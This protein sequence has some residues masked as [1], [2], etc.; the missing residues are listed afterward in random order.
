MSFRT[1]EQTHLYVICLE[2]FEIVAPDANLLGSSFLAT[3]Q[4]ESATKSTDYGAE[5]ATRVRVRRYTT[6]RNGENTHYLNF[7]VFLSV[8]DRKKEEDSEYVHLELT[9]GVTN[10]TICSTD[11]RLQ[12]FA[13]TD[14]FEPAHVELYSPGDDATAGVV[15]R[16]VISSARQTR[17][18]SEE[19][20]PH[21]S[22]DV[23]KVPTDEP[24][25]AFF[26]EELD[27]QVWHLFSTC[28]PEQAQEYVDQAQQESSQDPHNFAVD[29]L[30]TIHEGPESPGSVELDQLGISIERERRSASPSPPPHGIGSVEHEQEGQTATAGDEGGAERDDVIV[31]DVE[32]EHQ[33]EGGLE[34]DDRGAL[35]SDAF[36][37]LEG[38]EPSRPGSRKTSPTEQQKFYQTPIDLVN[39][40]GG[41]SSRTVGAQE[42]VSLGSE[43]NQSSILP[44][45]DDDD[46]NLPLPPI[47]PEL[48]TVKIVQLRKSPEQGGAPLFSQA[49]DRSRAQDAPPHGEKAAERHLSFSTSRGSPPLNEM[50]P[51][52]RDLSVS[53]RG[54]IEIDMRSGASPSEVNTGVASSS[55]SGPAVRKISSKPPTPD[56]TVEVQQ[57]PQ[58]ER[59]KPLTP[60]VIKE[61]PVRR[62]SGAGL[63]SSRGA[64][65]NVDFAQPPTE[66]DL[67]LSE[68]KSQHV[69]DL[70]HDLSSFT[71][72]SSAGCADVQTLHQ[73]NFQTG[74]SSSS[75]SACS[76]S[77]TVGPPAPLV[78]DNLNRSDTSARTAS[79]DS[80][81]KIFGGSA[82]STP[83]VATAPPTLLKQHQSSNSGAALTSTPTLQNTILRRDHQLLSD[84]TLA[85]TILPGTSNLNQ[86]ESL[87]R[88]VNTV[89]P[90]TE[91]NDS[92]S[93]A[94]TI[95][96]PNKSQLLD[97]SVQSLFSGETARRI[98]T[99]DQSSRTG[100]VSNLASTG[101]QQY[102]RGGTGA[103]LL[104]ANYYAKQVDDERKIEVQKTSMAGSGVYSDPPAAQA[105]TSSSRAARLRSP[106]F[107][108]DEQEFR[109]QESLQQEVE[110]DAKPP[111][112]AEAQMRSKESNRSERPA[113]RKLGTSK[114]TSPMDIW[115]TASKESASVQH[116]QEPQVLGDQDLRGS[117]NVSD[118]IVKAATEERKEQQ[119]GGQEPPATQAKE[120]QGVTLLKTNKPRDIRVD[121]A[122][123][124]ASHD[125]ARFASRE[126][127]DNYHPAGAPAASNQMSKRVQ[128][129]IMQNR[130]PPRYNYENEQPRRVSVQSLH[131]EYDSPGEQ[132]GREVVTQSVVHQ[133]GAS[134]TSNQHQLQTIGNNGNSSSSS[135]TGQRTDSQHSTEVSKDRII[136]TGW[137]EPAPTFSLMAPDS[138]HELQFSGRKTRSRKGSEDLASAS[139][140]VVPQVLGAQPP[141][142]LTPP[143]LAQPQFGA[144]KPLP[145]SSAE[146][147]RGDVDNLLFSSGTS[148]PSSA[149]QVPRDGLL[150]PPP[151]P[152]TKAA[153]SASCSSSSAISMKN[154]GQQAAPARVVM[155][156]PRSARRPITPA[157]AT[158]TTATQPAFLQQTPPLPP[159][160][161]TRLKNTAV[162]FDPGLPPRGPPTTGG[163]ATAVPDVG[164]PVLIQ[165][166][167][168]AIA[169]EQ[170]AGVLQEHENAAFHDTAV[171]A[172]PTPTRMTEL[173]Q[174]N[175]PTLQH[176]VSSPLRKPETEDDLQRS[177]KIHEKIN[178]VAG[179]LETQLGSP[180]G[181]ATASS[182]AAKAAGA[183]RRNKS[184]PPK[185]RLNQ[186]VV[187]HV[188]ARPPAGPAGASRANAQAEERQQQEEKNF[189]EQIPMVKQVD[190][191]ASLD[192]TENELTPS[193]AQHTASSKRKLSYG[194][195][196][197]SA[198]PVSDIH[199]GQHPDVS[200]QNDVTN[201]S[202]VLAEESARASNTSLPRYML[203]RSNSPRKRRHNVVEIGAE[204]H[205]SSSTSAT[206]RHRVASRGASGPP[207]AGHQRA[208]PRQ[209]RLSLIQHLRDDEDDDEAGIPSIREPQFKP[210]D[211]TFSFAAQGGMALASG[212]LA[213]AASSSRPGSATASSSSTGPMLSD[214][215]NANFPVTTSSRRPSHESSVGSRSFLQQ[216]SQ[217]HFP[218]SLQR[219]SPTSDPTGTT[220]RLV[221]PVQNFPLNGYSS[222]SAMS[223]KNPTFVSVS[224]SPHEQNFGGQQEQHQ[225]AQHM[226]EQERK[227]VELQRQLH[228]MKMQIQQRKQAGAVGGA[229]VVEQQFAAQ[230]RAFPPQ[231][232]YQRPLAGNSNS[233]SASASSTT[234]RSATGFANTPAP[235]QHVEHWTSATA[236]SSRGYHTEEEASMRMPS[237]EA[238]GSSHR[239]GSLRPRTPR[240]PPRV[241]MQPSDPSGPAPLPPSRPSGPPSFVTRPS[242]VQQQAHIHGSHQDHFGATHY[243]PQVDRAAAIAQLVGSATPAGVASTSADRYSYAAQQQQLAAHAQ[244]PAPRPAAEQH[245][246]Q[247]NQ[248]HFLEQQK[249]AHYPPPGPRLRQELQPP[250]FVQQMNNERHHHNFG[251]NVAP[252]ARGQH[253]DPNSHI[254]GGPSPP[255]SGAAMKAHYPRPLMA[256]AAGA[257][258]T[259]ALPRGGGAMP[260]A[261]NHH[262]D[263]FVDIDD[264]L[265]H[266]R[267]PQI[268][269]PRLMREHDFQ[270]RSESHGST[271][272]I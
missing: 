232:L 90:D 203:P 170:S 136:W 113:N 93:G 8:H 263:L 199:P 39:A 161:D 206:T 58:D 104:R 258:A 208:V 267:V 172:P 257:G 63:S 253:H 92:V 116:Q 35:L 179:M 197:G 109:F 214:Q 272:G 75:T 71:M 251:D 132:E 14:N 98:L 84:D 180:V 207:H 178:K 212:G 254:R 74:G 23:E 68:Q 217:Q 238:G 185:T 182:T 15:A 265:H 226:D 11:I 86:N 103:N 41:P 249:A 162:I 201:D 65:S 126:Q 130:N 111:S 81:T 64:D 128:Q 165:R 269:V 24:E 191:S 246:P 43:S 110:V 233:G 247:R 240:D 44:E 196:R 186:R 129:A 228:E 231:T 26:V 168:I 77:T 30:S 91:Y 210:P 95:V 215:Q 17:V 48:P 211:R 202:S 82:T 221:P 146:G 112:F 69:V 237:N 5:D 156:R 262:T 115:P 59:S 195:G 10:A 160:G 55:S 31:E 73:T 20:L 169:K 119:S 192:D 173:I 200:N 52:R 80:A 102:I 181:A 235:R 266:A 239:S 27:A 174:K 259:T 99:P 124:F 264:Q 175:M 25:V 229:H 225:Q 89:L 224:S 127:D 34:V 131:T 49:D 213:A 255:G 83:A 256:A 209:T 7:V 158:T 135:T 163:S 137:E 223:S 88:S 72:N 22:Q 187:Q 29:H 220:A 106:V 141:T 4:L 66:D 123:T 245:F 148:G 57:R 94:A 1:L 51:G 120:G 198:I 12:D 205:A 40:G 234:P 2:S 139:G 193:Y 164:P 67:H 108:P 144:A 133:Q 151:L 6:S 114:S 60:E 260:G 100:P 183:I 250:A 97:N 155:D 171:V 134:A 76:S 105:A 13:Q 3:W 184:S 16:A 153:S 230:P 28:Y 194:G 125:S 189:E 216:H 261:S 70:V 222:G 176:Y 166:E 188:R 32:I 50:P 248:L 270:Q 78:T 61:R 36:G 42:V 242:P 38:K 45:D 118:F 53:H 150:L 159:D 241:H 79:P 21:S 54:L 190:Q 157:A 33:E 62:R 122:T 227:I 18:V 154:A 107:P 117:L 252:T 204:Q 145:T 121:Q 236:H 87:T 101:G 46:D 9:D 244:P 218:P 19:E 140:V 56:R 85:Q 96:N 152:P 149:V 138:P 37:V 167:A 271:Y 47:S 177:Q 142:S 268:G 219:P 243:A 143:V 147:G